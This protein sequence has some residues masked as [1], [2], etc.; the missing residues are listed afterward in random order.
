AEVL[1]PLHIRES[2]EPSWTVT[3]SEGP[4]NGWDAF[5]MSPPEAAMRPDNRTYA[6]PSKSVKG[7]IRHIYTI[8]SDAQ[9]PSVDLGRLNPADALFG[10]VGKG[11]NQALMG[12]LVFNFAT[13]ES[14]ELTWFKTP[15]PYTGWHFDP[16]KGE[17]Q[18]QEGRETSK[19]RIAETWRLFRHKPLPPFVKRLDDFTP[20]AVQ[21]NYFRAI[22]PGS[23]AKFTIRFWNLNDE[24]LKRLIWSVNL[25]PGLAHKIGHHRYLGFGSLKLRV[26]PESYFIDWSKRYADVPDEEW[27]RPIDVEKWL[28]HHVIAHYVAL[29][30]A[31]DVGAL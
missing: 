29:M 24:E 14:P 30:K 27:Q 19:H 21:A 2:G 17:W 9:Q 12:R 4:V 8:A 11:T 18:M 10:W 6:L 26:L 16:V 25:Q 28:D 23:K 3:L 1:T 5:S 7:M 20:D 31:L 13:F 15:Y 22:M